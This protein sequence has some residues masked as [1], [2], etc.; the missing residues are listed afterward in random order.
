MGCIDDIDLPRV[1][2]LP[3]RHILEPVNRWSF[4]RPDC[5]CE[6]IDLHEAGIVITK[7]KFRF[8][9]LFSR[10][11]PSIEIQR[12]NAYDLVVA[13]DRSDPSFQ[14]VDHSDVG[15]FGSSAL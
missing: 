7:I 2:S 12:V 11:L 3:D 14:R 8:K 9:I 15:R 4:V 6:Q 10:I 1:R 5:S 13:S